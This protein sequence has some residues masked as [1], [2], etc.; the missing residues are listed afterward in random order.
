MSSGID[1]NRV[2]AYYQKMSDAEII[3]A[4]T[5]DARGLTEEGLQI[6]KE[7]VGRSPGSAL[8]LLCK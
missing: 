6:V 7:E 5:N 1:R 4:L 8:W 3:N 2:L